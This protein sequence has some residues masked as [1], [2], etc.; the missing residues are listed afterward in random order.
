MAIAATAGFDPGTQSFTN[1]D[2]GALDMP[3][4]GYAVGFHTLFNTPSIM[5][6][7]FDLQESHLKPVVHDPAEAPAVT[8]SDVMDRETLRA[9]VNEVIDFGRDRLAREGGNALISMKAILRDEMGPW[10]EGSV[11]IYMLDTTG[12]IWFHAA[13]PHRY[14]FTIAGRA[15]MRSP[16]KSFL[17]WSARQPNRA[18]RAASSS[19][20]STI[21]T[22]IPTEWTYP[23]SSSRASLPVRGRC[24]LSL[25]PVTI[26]QQVRRTP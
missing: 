17:T 7:G 3:L 12:Y 14:E 21:P 20:I 9:F 11:Y 4:S 19:I 1:P 25:P 18:R 26:R 16:E 15:E 22:M 23:R 6:A 10:R 24:P 5:T 2:G 8:A 13:F